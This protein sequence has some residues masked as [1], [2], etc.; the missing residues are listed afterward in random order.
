MIEMER[1]VC[2]LRTGRVRRLPVLAR[3]GGVRVADD[4]ELSMNDRIRQAAAGNSAYDLRR[5]GLVPL[6]PVER[7]LV[8]AGVPL[9]VALV[10]ADRVEG[11]TAEAQAQDAQRLAE[12][13]LRGER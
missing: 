9:Q 13:V 3:R 4:D 7:A 1:L 6:A 10:L 11:D 2:S 8:D 5:V 12:A